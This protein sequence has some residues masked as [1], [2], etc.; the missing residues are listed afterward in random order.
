MTFNHFDSSVR[1]NDFWTLPMDRVNFNLE[2]NH[3]K[4]SFQKLG[5]AAVY[6]CPLPEDVR[7]G[8]TTLK[9]ALERT[10]KA[11][12]SATKVNWRKDL[13]ALHFSIYGLIMPDDY[14]Q[15]TCWP[16]SDEQLQKLTQALKQFGKFQ[17]HLQGAGIL[18][19]GAISVRVSD[20]PELEKLRDAIA[21][22][23]G[24]SKERFGSRTKKIVLGRLI[25]A[26]TKE[27]RDIVRRACDI[28]QGFSIG[29]LTIDAMEIVQYQNTLLE[30]IADRVRIA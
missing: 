1:T 7:Q 11:M 6:G 29:T 24:F 2:K 9:S 12:G 15:E 25:P 18:G 21:A 27:D 22:I 5:V 14:L 10:M 17:L 3:V 20:S 30:I 16:L 13:N 19:M 28:L 8:I 26:L 4:D 23:D